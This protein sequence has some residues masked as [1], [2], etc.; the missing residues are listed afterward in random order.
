MGLK[1]HL[2]FQCCWNE[3]FKDMVFYPFSVFLFL[4]FSLT[5]FIFLEENCLM[6]PAW[7]YIRFYDRLSEEY[8]VISLN[9]IVRG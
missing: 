6:S 1:L 3:M 4:R 8:Y 2:Q 5:C 7:Q 9:V